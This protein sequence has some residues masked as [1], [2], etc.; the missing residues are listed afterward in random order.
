M[1]QNP[2][3]VSLMKIADVKAKIHYDNILASQTNLLFLP[4]AAGY[5]VWYTLVDFV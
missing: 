2:A 5:A 3:Y 4:L 1:M